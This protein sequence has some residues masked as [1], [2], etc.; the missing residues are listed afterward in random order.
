[1]SKMIEDC[2]VHYEIL[3]NDTKEYVGKFSM[4]SHKGDRK[5]DY[6]VMRIKESLEKELNNLTL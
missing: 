6:C 4:E 1:M 3:K 5:Y 2:M